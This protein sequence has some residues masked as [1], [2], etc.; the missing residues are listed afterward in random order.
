M[1]GVLSVVE[2]FLNHYVDNREYLDNS[3]ARGVPVCNSAEPVVGRAACRRYCL[4][5]LCWTP[6]VARLPDLILER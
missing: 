3:I 1:P 6:L 4:Y 5:N 2:T